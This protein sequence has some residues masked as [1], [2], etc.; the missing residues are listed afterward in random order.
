MATTEDIGFKYKRQVSNDLKAKAS[1]K[2][3]NQTRV[4]ATG[5]ERSDEMEGISRCTAVTRTLDVHRMSAV[6]RGCSTL[7]SPNTIGGS[8]LFFSRSRIRRRCFL[9]PAAV[10]IHAGVTC[11]V[12]VVIF[13]VVVFF[14]AV[15]LILEPDIP[16]KSF[17]PSRI[18]STQLHVKR[19]LVPSSAR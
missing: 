8:N 13:V 3:G 6:L 5:I 17:I 7:M 11:L 18:W 10:V 1:M 4:Q 2:Q 16:V 9:F 19:L 15:I 12:V 14:A